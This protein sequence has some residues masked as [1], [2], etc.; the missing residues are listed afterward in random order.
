MSRSY[1]H[2]PIIKDNG[3]R[4]KWAKRQAN[5]KIRRFKYPIA[6]GNAYRKHYCSYDICD[7]AHRWT[8]EDAIRR[9]HYSGSR[10]WSWSDDYPTEEDFINHYWAKTF[11]WK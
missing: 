7:W 3:S 5:K 6:N 8:K 1:R 9:Y 4:K 10:W 2:T 11:Y